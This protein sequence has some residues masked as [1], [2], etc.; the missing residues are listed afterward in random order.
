MLKLKKCAIWTYFGLMWSQLAI[1]G[2]SMAMQWPRG[3][4]APKNSKSPLKFTKIAKKSA[5]GG[6]WWPLLKTRWVTGDVGQFNVKNWSFGHKCLEWTNT[7]PNTYHKPMGHVMP[8]VLDSSSLFK[9][10]ILWHIIEIFEIICHIHDVSW[11]WQLKKWPSSTF[12][13]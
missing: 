6:L 12:L 5:W 7:G 9:C 11:V 10:H 4:F 3:G 13:W 8:Q 2:D 1:Y